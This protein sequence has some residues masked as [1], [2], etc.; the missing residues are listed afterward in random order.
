MEWRLEP[1]GPSRS[2]HGQVSW[3]SCFV[4]CCESCAQD[5]KTVV[6]VIRVSLCSF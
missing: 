4:A 3:G 5:V 2:A 6:L 1:I